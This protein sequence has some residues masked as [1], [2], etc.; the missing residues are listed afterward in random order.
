M[1]TISV[2]NYF[3]TLMMIKNID[4]LR[5]LKQFIKV[6]KKPRRKLVKKDK[7]PVS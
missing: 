6:K 2:K 7:K 5:A 4:F 1:E 3:L